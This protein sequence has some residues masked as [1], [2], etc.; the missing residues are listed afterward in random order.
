MYAL[1]LWLVVFKFLFLVWVVFWGLSGV[2]V[3]TFIQHG[4]EPKPMVVATK[5]K[6]PQRLMPDISAAT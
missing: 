5:T 3:E 2:V 6:K 1:L 4:V